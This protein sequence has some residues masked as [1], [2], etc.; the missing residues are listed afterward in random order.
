MDFPVR[1][2]TRT[3]DLSAAD[4]ERVRKSFTRLARYH[5]RIISAHVT[6]EGPGAHHRSGGPYRV[7]ATIKIPRREIIVDRQEGEA[8]MVTVRQA[9]EAARRQLEDQARLVAGR[10]K[11]HP[12]ARSPRAA[13][14]R[15]KPSR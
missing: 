14:R 15:R 6:L 8:L 2:T 5:D 13:P 7:K 4:E 1:F 11:E 12:P 3:L 9:C 10:V